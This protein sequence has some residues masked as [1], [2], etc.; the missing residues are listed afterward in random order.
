MNVLLKFSL[1]VRDKVAACDNAGRFSA[2][3]SQ[4]EDMAGAEGRGLGA[5][6]IVVRFTQPA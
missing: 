3:G 4:Q 5:E 1:A 2:V 6:L